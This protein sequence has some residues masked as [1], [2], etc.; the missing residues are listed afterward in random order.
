MWRNEAFYSVKL[1]LSIFINSSPGRTPPPSQTKRAVETVRV[2]A[3]RKGGSCI[4]KGPRQS[5]AAHR[6]RK[7]VGFRFPGER[8]L[9][10]HPARPASAAFG[11]LVSCC[12]QGAAP[13]SNMP[14]CLR[15]VSNWFDALRPSPCRYKGD[16]LPFISLRDGRPAKGKREPRHGPSTKK[17]AMGSR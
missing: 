11:P 1:E 9:G 17:G 12:A 7:K 2:Y 14:A 4:E 13:F 6:R 8:R 16:G 5:F 10:K 15:S 3:G